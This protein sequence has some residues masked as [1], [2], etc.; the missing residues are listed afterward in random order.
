[1]IN[2]TKYCSFRCLKF[3]PKT[4]FISKNSFIIQYKKKGTKG[5]LIKKITKITI[6]T[7]FTKFVKRFKHSFF[8]QNI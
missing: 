2:I 7:T 3:K 4:E 8:I 6:Q 1:M 5:F